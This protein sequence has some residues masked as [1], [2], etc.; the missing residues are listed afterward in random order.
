MFMVHLYLL[1]DID[2]DSDSQTSNGPMMSEQ[3]FTTYLIEMVSVKLMFI[4]SM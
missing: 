3:E 4:F 2:Y 1:T